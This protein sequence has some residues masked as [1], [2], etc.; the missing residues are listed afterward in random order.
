[1]RYGRPE[2]MQV[3]G[4]VAIGVD[5]MTAGLTSEVLAPARTKAAATRATLTGVVRRQ[6][7]DETV[8]HVGLGERPKPKGAPARVVPA[9]RPQNGRSATQTGQAFETDPRT[10]LN[11]ILDDTLYN[12]QGGRAFLAMAKAKGFARA[13]R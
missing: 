1:M 11:R 3:I 7:F 2:E 6:D 4:H 9:D 8:G 12:P 13:F 5:L 10:H